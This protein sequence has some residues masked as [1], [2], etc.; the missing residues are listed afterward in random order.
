M[1]VTQM[2]SLDMTHKQFNAKLNDI[3]TLRR[4]FAGVIEGQVRVLAETCEASCL[5]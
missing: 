2:G 5:P 1:T 4:T 3:A